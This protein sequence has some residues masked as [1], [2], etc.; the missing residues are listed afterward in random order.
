V[1]DILNTI[2]LSAKGKIILLEACKLSIL[3]FLG[4]I[5]NFPII[6]LLVFI[7]VLIGFQY[8]RLY[9]IENNGDDRLMFVLTP[10]IVF[11]F[12]ETFF[13]LEVISYYFYSGSFN[14]SYFFHL[15]FNSVYFASAF[16]W[17]IV[18]IFIILAFLIVTECTIYN[19][20]R[21]CIFKKRQKYF[22]YILI[23]LTIFLIPNSHSRFLFFNNN[24]N[25]DQ[26]LQENNPN[27]DVASL[28][29]KNNEMR[30]IDQTGNPK[31]IIFLYLE[32][33]EYEF[34]DVEKYPDLMPNLSK[35]V[36]ESG[37]G[38]VKIK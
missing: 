35:L 21:S 31:N 4:L 1:H 24:H 11:I 26:A 19:L 8:F 23:L 30:V 29:F 33:L 6:E 18:V 22:L 5:V 3:I 28:Y 12:L 7:L 17:Q 15:N 20:Q 38:G 13:I 14:T 34:L 9:S 25:I 36:K 37:G 2:S 10:L 32:S 27:I 16:I